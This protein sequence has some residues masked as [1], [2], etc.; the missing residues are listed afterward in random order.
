MFIFTPSVGLNTNDSNPN[1]SFRNSVAIT[2]GSN[3]L[4]RATFAASGAAALIANNC[5]IGVHAPAGSA[6]ET[7]GTPTELLFSGGHGFSISAGQTIPSDFASL[8]FAVSDRLIVIVDVGTNGGNLFSTAN[9]NCDCYFGNGASYNQ[10]NPAFGGGTIL[11]KDYM[12]F[13]VETNDAAGVPLAGGFA[14][15][16]W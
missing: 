3:G 5:S 15:S 6:W 14:E 4:V 13:S 7:I 8:N 2:G 10:S 16:E 12:V 11:T 9:G 1:I